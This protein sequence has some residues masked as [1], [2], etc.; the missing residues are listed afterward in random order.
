MWSN[1]R[2]CPFIKLY[3]NVHSLQKNLRAN[4]LLFFLICLLLFLMSASIFL[5]DTSLVSVERCSVILHKLFFSAALCC[6][7]FVALPSALKYFKGLF[8]FYWI[9]IRGRT[10][11]G[12]SFHPF[13]GTRLLGKQTCIHRAIS[14]CHISSSFCMSP[15]SYIY[16]F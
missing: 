14:K 6:R 2:S 15:F 16:I 1:Y 10:C 13:P 8:F 3:L 12:H 4:F 5:D 11:L 7:A 9:Q